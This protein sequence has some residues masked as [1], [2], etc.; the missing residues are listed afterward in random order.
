[1]CRVVSWCWDV[2]RYSTRAVHSN[3]EFA[4]S[5]RV[6][7]VGDGICPAHDALDKVVPTVNWRDAVDVASK[8]CDGRDGLG[9]V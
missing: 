2:V 7:D 9:A 8:Q 3:E 6:L 5:K 1:M 4:V